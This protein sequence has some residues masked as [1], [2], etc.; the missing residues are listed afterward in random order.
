M[1]K[2][3]IIP[4]IGLL[5]LALCA[6]ASA[7]STTYT[8][9]DNAKVFD[10]WTQSDGAPSSIL[11]NQ[12][13]I[14]MPNFSNATTA[15]RMVIELD[16]IT[17]NRYLTEFEVYYEAVNNSVWSSLRVGNLLLD[18]NNGSNDGWNYAVKLFNGVQ[19]DGSD[20]G[21]SIYNLPNLPIGH[22]GATWDNDTYYLQAKDG[23]QYEPYTGIQ[24]FSNNLNTR[25]PHPI[26]I[27]ETYLTNAN[28]T[29]AYFDGW[30]SGTGQMSSLIEF[31]GMG[32]DLGTTATR[33]QFGFTVNCA[34]DVLFD[35]TP[36]PRIPT[37]PEPGTL[38]LLGTGLVGLVGLRRRNQA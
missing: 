27:K 36:I 17:G 11:S 34:N 24:T 8:F 12:D 14:V 4:L 32:L 33:L 15:V 16:E 9:K 37:I 19:T 5:G 2:I 26:G 31:S 28:S 35:G 22:T 20:P 25:N 21:Y 30:K 10:G 38:L 1:R 6:P 29:V 23:I 18:T 13:L 7:I 3:L